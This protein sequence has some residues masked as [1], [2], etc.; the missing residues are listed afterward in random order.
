MKKMKME[1]KTLTSQNHISLPQPP[2]NFTLNQNI[3]LPLFSFRFVMNSNSF[4]IRTPESSTDST[5]A[6]FLSTVSTHQSY[7]CA[8]IEDGCDAAAV[9]GGVCVA[10]SGLVG[11]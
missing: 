1:K 3:I 7:G 6:P 2:H 9:D 4:Q 8:G 10:G 5:T 11:C